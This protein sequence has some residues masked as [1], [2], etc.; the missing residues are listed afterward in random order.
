MKYL[1]TFLLLLVSN[2]LFC[3]CACRS[4][5]PTETPSCNCVEE[6]SETTT[7]CDFI[8]EVDGQTPGTAE[9]FDDNGTLKVRVVSTLTNSCNTA[10][11][12]QEVEEWFLSS[13]NCHRALFNPGAADE[14]PC[15][16]NID[17][18]FE[19]IGGVPNSPGV[20]PIQPS[21]CA[22][23]S[24]VFTCAN[25]RTFCFDSQCANTVS[26]QSDIGNGLQP[27]EEQY[28]IDGNDFCVLD[29]SA[30]RQINFIVKYETSYTSNDCEQTV[31]ICELSDI[32]TYVNMFPVF[33]QTGIQVSYFTQFTDFSPQ[34]TLLEVFDPLINTWIPI[35]QNTG[36]ISSNVLTTAGT[37]GQEE[38]IKV[39]ISADGCG[40]KEYSRRVTYDGSQWVIQ[41]GGPNDLSELI[42]CQ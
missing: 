14:I 24:N 3:Q 23:Q 1:N 28:T 37:T 11:Y 9:V 7:S 35:D 30:R 12:Y 13:T 42:E 16:N 31:E 15:L 25:I 38:F 10:I 19:F 41:S 39:R 6:Y 21:N 20:Y 8:L 18:Q 33:G 40:C 2:I 32:R 36:I 4:V 27:V 26:I 22:T 17:Y 5:T 29:P 34:S